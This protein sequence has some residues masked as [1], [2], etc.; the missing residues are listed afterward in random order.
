MPSPQWHGVYAVARPIASPGNCFCIALPS[1]IPAGRLRLAI[2]FIILPAWPGVKVNASRGYS[3]HIEG[4]VAKRLRLPFLRRSSAIVNNRRDSPMPL[5][6]TNTMRMTWIAGHPC[7]R[8]RPSWHSALPWLRLM[9][10][11]P[12]HRNIPF[13]CGRVRSTAIRGTKIPNAKWKSKG[14]LVPIFGPL[15]LPAREHLS[16][17]TRLVPLIPTLLP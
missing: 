16:K 17:L 1:A 2:V 9:A 11:S 15:S 8:V 3:D 6:L 10:P 13:P 12:H 14:T 4:V 5:L 7:T